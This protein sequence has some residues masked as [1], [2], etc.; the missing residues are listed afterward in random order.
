[1]DAK[2][3]GEFVE[4]QDIFLSWKFLPRGYL[5][6]S[7]KKG[8]H[9]SNTY[10]HTQKCVVVWKMPHQRYQIPIPGSCLSGKR[11]FADMTKELE[12]GDHPGLPQQPLNPT[13]GILIRGIARVHGEGNMQ[14]KQREVWRGEPWRLQWCY[15]KPRSEGSH[16][17]LRGKILPSH[18]RRSTALPT[19]WLQPSE[20]D[21]WLLASRKIRELVSYHF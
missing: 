13:T 11:V 10:T 19:T 5:T 16:Q 15:Q 8:K 9:T 12:M 6:A 21:F 4:E 3:T 1:M 7:Y 17:N 2:S 20:A 14:T 18:L